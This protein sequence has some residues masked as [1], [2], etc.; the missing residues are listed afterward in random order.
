MH[1]R[2][3]QAPAGMSTAPAVDRQ[4]RERTL[5]ARLVLLVLALLIPALV[6]ASILTWHS[7]RQ[8]YAAQE[9]QLT[10]SARTLSLMVEGRL[11]EQAGL[12]K[13]LATS[14]RL[15]QGDW[16]GFDAQARQAIGGDGWI[17]VKD[18]SGQQLVNTRVPFGASLPRVTLP[19]VPQNENQRDDG[20][21]ISGLAM[22]LL[23]K[24]P[25]LVMVK[26]V[27]L[28]DGREV[29]LSLVTPSSTYTQLVKRQQ[30]PGS[31]LATVLDRDHRVIARSREEAR[32]QGKPALRLITRR[33]E[34][35]GEGALWA[36]SLDGAPMRTAYA[37]IP[38]SDWHVLVGVPREELVGPARRTLIV[39]AGLAIVLLAAGVALAL[40][41]ARE[42]SHAVGRLRLATA[43]G[44]DAGFVAPERSGIVEL[45]A[46]AGDFEAAAA[47]V[48]ER[49]A[50][51]RLLMNEL[52]HR[53]K[54]TLATIQSVAKHTRGGATSVEQF[55]A[56]LEGRILAMSGAHELLTRSD[57]A[58]ADLQELAEDALRP[59][60]GPRLRI[61]G[62]KVGVEPTDAL[63]LTLIFYELATNAAKYGALSGP[64]GV[65]EL[66]WRAEADVVLIS[67]REQGGP[68]VSAPTRH[69]FGSRLI[70]RARQSLQPSDL[71]Y[72]PT[73]VRCTLTLKARRRS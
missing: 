45:D 4:T 35:G 10:V 36:K 73:G 32:F 49:E 27:R 38:N 13:A 50:Q 67:W 23:A 59:F 5:R 71:A 62:P 53:V 64:N 28:E 16:E 21:R 22:G 44:V 3:K 47:R 60:A 65:A 30:L 42:I 1:A 39:G 6:L 12:L 63:N 8:A 26:A 48:G 34:S 55:H 18:L 43:R 61:S 66:S 57:W 20:L 51:Q 33:L 68:T 41:T 37:P 11:N 2:V 70:D 14:A 17:A 31:W 46:L 24:E 25:V 72:D 29:D 69:G 52:N 40:R 19:R 54:N 7:T 9:R 56:A 15:R 58:S